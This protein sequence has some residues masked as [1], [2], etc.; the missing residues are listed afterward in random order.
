MSEQPASVPAE[1]SGLRVTVVGLG[2]FGGGVGV[3]R[4]LAGQG[5][6]VTVSDQADA[7]S[8]AESIAKLSG[9]DVELHFGGHLRADFLTADLLVVN[10]AV[11]KQLPLL[12]EARAAGVPRTSEMNLFLQRCPACVVGVTGTV[13]KS[14]TAAMIAQILSRQ[15][16][17]HLGG[18]IGVSLLD[19]L[20]EMGPDHL[21]VLELS[22]F[23]LEDLPIV[24]ISPHVAVV[25]NFSANHLDRHGT[26]EA[27]AEAKRNIFKFQR[28][29]DVLVLN[30]DCSATADW[31]GRAH[32]RVEWFDPSGEPFELTVPGPHNQA[33]AQAAWTACRLF[34]VDRPAAAA[35]LAAYQALPHRL[36]FVAEKAGVRFYDDSKCTTPDGAIVAIESFDA[37]EV[38]IIVGG[39]D[40]GAEFGSLGEALASRAK[41][42]IAMGATKRKI[43]A[44]IE[45][46]AGSAAFELA[47]DLAGAF[48]AARRH[49]EPGDVVL[50]APACASYD[51][52]LNYQ[53]RGQQFTELVQKLS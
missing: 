19:K 43:A 10:T 44:A 30:R 39:Y 37:G 27:Y 26:V 25:T 49:A 16:V 9:L 15:Y 51:M 41:A 31:T 50:L 29:E 12:A 32:G 47:D 1:L 40:K 7:E 38:V 48:Q 18:N 11:P 42:V 4:W 2:R 21:V 17:T 5:A 8:L 46:A 6:K 13:G 53:H 45:G 28:A 22:S 20:P 23:Q 24:G 33:N 14:T 36:S 35:A 3:T 52:F 34:G